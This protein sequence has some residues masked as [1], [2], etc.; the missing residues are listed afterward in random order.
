MSIYHS[1][2]A[3]K[4]T[5]ESF[6]NFD[7]EVSETSQTQGQTL[8]NNSQNFKQNRQ[9]KEN[10]NFQTSHEIVFVKPSATLLGQV[11]SK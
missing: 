11:S 8:F 2:T 6:V 5:S 10:F 3:A 1:I 4:K 9:E 7:L